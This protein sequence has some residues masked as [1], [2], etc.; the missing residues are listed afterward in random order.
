VRIESHGGTP[1]LL[2]EGSKP[3]HLRRRYHVFQ[4][5]ADLRRH[6][7]QQPILPLRRQQLRGLLL[8]FGCGC[9]VG[10]FERPGK[11]SEVIP[12]ADLRV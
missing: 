7:I 1:L 3:L 5:I 12:T 11:M 2:G 6:P 9:S 8:L 4:Q 10:A